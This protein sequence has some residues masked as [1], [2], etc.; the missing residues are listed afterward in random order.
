[1]LICCKNSQPE[2]A[3]PRLPHR[4]CRYTLSSGHLDDE[5]GNCSKMHLIIVASVIHRMF[6]NQIKSARANEI[7]SPSA[8]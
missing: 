8:T 7:Y 4:C 2:D 3:R 5:M 6:C 1:M